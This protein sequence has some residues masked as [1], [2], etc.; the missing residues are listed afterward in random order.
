MDLTMG[1]FGSLFKEKNKWEDVKQSEQVYPINTI[2]LLTIKTEHVELTTGWIDKGYEH[3][4]FKKYCPDNFLI[5]VHFGEGHSSMLLHQIEMFFAD[6][7]RE[8]CIAHMIARV[9]SKENVS[10]EL[11]VDDKDAAEQ[12]LK[13]IQSDSS[14][15]FSF[16]WEVTHDPKW[17]LVKGLMHL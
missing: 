12:Q 14:L 2:S 8:V 10:I 3:Y 5:I 4:E 13:T 1:I 6:K 7:L 15:A 17:K 11:Y 16:E 9:V